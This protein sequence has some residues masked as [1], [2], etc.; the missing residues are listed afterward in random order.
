MWRV[1]SSRLTLDSDFDRLAV[2]LDRMKRSQWPIQ[3]IR[4]DSVG[5][6]G[7]G[8]CEKISLSGTRALELRYCN[9]S[10]LQNL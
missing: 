8:I 9:S 4:T 5:V 2:P 6:M 7:S 10:G 3:L 1:D